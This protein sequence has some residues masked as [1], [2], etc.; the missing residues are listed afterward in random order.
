[1]YKSNQNASSSSIPLSSVVA[2]VGCDGTGKSTLSNDL[3]KHLSAKGTVKRRYLGTISGEVGDKI[4]ALP[5]IGIK[6]ERYLNE[7]AQRAQD[8]K[9]KLPGTGTALIMYFFSWWRALHLLNVRRLSRKG[10]VIIADRFPQAEISGFHYD[11]PG[12]TIDRTNN[13]LIKR[14][15]IREQKLYEWMATQKPSLII[16]LNIDAETAYSRKPDHNIEELRD[17]SS[18]MPKIG[19]NDA[20]IYD[21]DARLPYDE[22]LASA[23]S[24]IEKYMPNVNAV[25]K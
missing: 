1:M 2:I 21:I 4:K 3:Y 19:F 24:A 8:I 17:K 14:L 10:I 9:K 16:R 7:K 5:L 18:I 20:Q 23:L 12:L 25:N 22:V 6:L 13:W 15:A 11:G